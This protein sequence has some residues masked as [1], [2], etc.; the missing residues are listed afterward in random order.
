LLSRLNLPP[1]A[2]TRMIKNRMR[3]NSLSNTSPQISVA[4]RSEYYFQ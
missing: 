4:G 1:T 2:I 3:I